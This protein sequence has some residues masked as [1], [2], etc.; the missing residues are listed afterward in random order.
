MLKY[1]ETTGAH[2]ENPLT[3]EIRVVFVTHWQRGEVLGGAFAD[4]GMRTRKVKGQ[5]GV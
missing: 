3:A 5:T 2:T 1:T 4:L